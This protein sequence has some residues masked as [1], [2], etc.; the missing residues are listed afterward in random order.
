MLND[1]IK[2]YVDQY[3]HMEYLE[4]DVDHLNLITPKK[5]ILTYKNF[6]LSIYHKYVLIEVDIYF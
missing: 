5:K 1:E 4:H 2:I 3:D 6:F